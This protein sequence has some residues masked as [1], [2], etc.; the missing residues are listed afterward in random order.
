MSEVEEAGGAA[1]SEAA[2]GELAETQDNP[3]QFEGMKQV[4]SRAD[5]AAAR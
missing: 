4:L 1:V 5:G 3:R 2:G